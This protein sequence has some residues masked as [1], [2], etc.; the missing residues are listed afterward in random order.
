MSKDKL[1]RFGVPI[2]SKRS[3]GGKKIV[4]VIIIVLIIVGA[5][6]FVW[7]PKGETKNKTQPKPPSPTTYTRILEVVEG[8]TYGLLMEQ[9]ALTPAE[10]QGIFEAAEEV[11]SLANVRLGRTLDLV[12]DIK[13]DELKK[14]IYRI[15]SEDELHVALT[16][17]TT[18]TT[19][20]PTWAAERIPIPYEVKI[21]TAQGVIATSM[22]EAALA[23]GIDEIAVINFADVFQW[24]V[25]FAWEVQKGDSFKFIYEQRYRDGKY[26]MPGKIIAGKFINEGKELYA[27]YYP[28]EE[29]DGYFDATGQSVQKIFLKAP[30]AFKYISSGFTT[31]SRY[32][33][34]F[35]IATG[36][37]AID[38][39]ATY[40]T[41]VRAVGDG[42]VVLAGWQSGYGNKVS[43][44]HNSTYTTNYAHMSKIAVGYGQ[45]V[46]QGQTVGYVGSTG[47][48][49]GPHLHYEMVK[50]GTKIN[51][52]NEEFPST[53]SIKE[54]NR[55]AYL[56]TI[57][58]L[59]KQLDN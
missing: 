38:Y 2:K 50:Y 35:N 19:T 25:D 54:E 31:G 22:Y 36:H 1:N 14:L 16:A 44:R 15:D 51:P 32:I 53:E 12:Y 37:R 6:F 18:A 57:Q 4:F 58:N 13:T 17:S 27:F 45:K 8:S 3:F 41:P 26:V 21:K 42:T 5:A 20:K 7:R 52:F 47:L 11:Y 9:A 10:S 39:A 56:A 49:T 48:S 33:Q 46:T 55:E 24:S 40:G 28:N 30:L 23:Q 43:V 29:T 59:K 34:A